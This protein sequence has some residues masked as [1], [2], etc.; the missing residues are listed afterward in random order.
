[1]RYV[2]MNPSGNLTALV[3][4]WGG[5]GEEPEITRRL[6]RKSEPVA[7]LE[8][9]ALPGALARVRLMGGEF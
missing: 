8:A 5:A 3:P 9:P 7:Y 4:E 1:M 2:I 6:M